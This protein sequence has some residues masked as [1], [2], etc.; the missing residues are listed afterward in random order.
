MIQ[1]SP[2]LP[3]TPTEGLYLAMDFSREGWLLP[4]ET[5]AS[6]VTGSW[7]CRVY[8]GT[9]LNPQA[10]I[11][12]AATID[13]TKVRQLVIGGLEG[14]VYLFLCT[15]VTNTGRTLVGRAIL[16]VSTAA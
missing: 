7:A 8:S 11:S 16:R 5:I 1:F 14:V 10:M 4:G 13:G 6:I 2:E 9:D 15:F 12:G 3:K